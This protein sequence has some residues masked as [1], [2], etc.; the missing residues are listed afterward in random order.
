MRPIEKGTWPSNT[1]SL[2]LQAAKEFLYSRIGPYCCYCEEY[3][4]SLQNEHIVSV[5]QDKDKKFDWENLVLGCGNC[6][7]QGNKGHQHVDIENTHFPHLDNTLLSFEY[8]AGGKIKVNQNLN[9]V[10]FNKATA[11]F[12][13]VGLDRDP[14]NPEYDSKSFDY[15]WKKRLEVWSAAQII[16][17]LHQEALSPDPE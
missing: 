7:G 11:L 14:S 6:N 15:R 17:N 1:P 10:E 3:S 2:T 16:L 5:H 12:R 8:L 13:L 4:A 9:A